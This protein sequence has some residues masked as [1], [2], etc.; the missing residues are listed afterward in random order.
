[1]AEHGFSSGASGGAIAHCQCWCGL[2][3]HGSTWNAA[4]SKLHAHI[5]SSNQRAI[6]TWDN[7]GGSIPGAYR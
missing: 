7:E 3:F 4:Y 2:R 5:S 1:M 6:H